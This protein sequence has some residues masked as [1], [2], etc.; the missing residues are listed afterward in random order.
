MKS[1]NFKMFFYHDFE[2]IMEYLSIINSLFLI[3][4]SHL[5]CEIKVREEFLSDLN[6]QSY[7]FWSYRDGKVDLLWKK[8]FTNSIL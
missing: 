5:N 6:I 4:S 8:M 7:R 2:K 1:F 3:K